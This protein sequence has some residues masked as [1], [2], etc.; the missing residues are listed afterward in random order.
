MNKLIWVL[1]ECTAAATGAGDVAQGLRAMGAC[2]EEPAWLPCQQGSS[3]L[4]VI[5]VIGDL[6]L[7][8]GLCSLQEEY[9]CTDK[10]LGK[11]TYA[12]KI[13]INEK[14]LKAIGHRYT[15]TEDNWA[16]VCEENQFRYGCTYFQCFP[17]S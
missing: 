4:S 2:P 8:S 14:F 12:C 5:S 17:F 6:T 13:K 11:T 16:I 15:F 10:H 1:Q 3:H 9:W 7:P